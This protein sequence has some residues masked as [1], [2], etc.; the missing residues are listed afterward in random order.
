M[1]KKLIL[2]QF[3][4]SLSKEFGKRCLPSKNTKKGVRK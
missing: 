1:A 4:N 2:S 3:G